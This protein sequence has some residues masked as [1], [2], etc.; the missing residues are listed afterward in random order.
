MAESPAASYRR[1]AGSARGVARRDAIL[2]A[3]VDDLAEN[4]L[5][6][7]SLRRLARGAGTTHRVLLYHFDGIEDLLAQALRELRARR[8]DNVMSAAPPGS[9]LSVHVR[10]FWPVLADDATGLRAID[11]AIGLAM[12]DPEKF[13]HLAREASDMYR[14]PLAALCPPGWSAARRIEVVELVLAAMRGCLLEW[15]TAHDRPAIE[16]ALNALCRAIERE[17]ACPD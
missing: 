5:G 7:A 17:E 10:A 8:I 3:V 16:A 6:D 9:P 13:G 4:G 11:E 2:L 1:S 14:G 12:Y 15:R